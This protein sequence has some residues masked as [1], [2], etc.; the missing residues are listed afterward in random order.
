MLEWTI[1]SVRDDSLGLTNVAEEIASLVSS[2]CTAFQQSAC[3]EPI[4]ELFT[5]DESVGRVVVQFP[6]SAELFDSF[7]NGHFG[8]RGFFRQGPWTGTVVNSLIISEIKSALA[9]KLSETV[10]AHVLKAGPRLDGKVTLERSTLL[11]SLDPNLAKVWYS[12]AV[13]TSAGELRLLPSGVSAEKINVGLREPWMKI[14]QE[15]GDC[16]IEVKG[17][18]VGMNGLFQVKDPEKRARS[19]SEHGEA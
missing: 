4:W 2:M 11:R 6:V 12:T 9:P 16:V 5:C 14:I 15:P 19:L 7:F 8:Y 10:Q 17:A 1:S 13:V 18:F 3:I